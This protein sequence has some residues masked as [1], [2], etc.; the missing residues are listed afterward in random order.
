VFER[1][2]TL[3]LVLIE[4]GFAWLPSLSWRLDRAW[5]M[6]R[7]E[8]PHLQRQ[9]SATIKEHVWL[10]TQ[11]ME[12]PS[13]P[14]FFLQLLEQLDMN[15]RLMFATDYPHWDFDAPDQAFPVRLPPELKQQIQRD[16]AYALYRL[17]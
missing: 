16:N 11:P 4:S 14:A 2:P 3:K 6:L 15:D 5:K 7:D 17:G 1:F 12:E 10:T 8:V 13:R 9:P